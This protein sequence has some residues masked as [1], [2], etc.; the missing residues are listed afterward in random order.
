MSEQELTVSMYREQY[1]DAQQR[2]SQAMIEDDCVFELACVTYGDEF[3]QAGEMVACRP[4]MRILPESGRYQYGILA[5]VAQCNSH[6]LA[7]EE[8]YSSIAYEIPFFEVE[9]ITEETQ[10]PAIHESYYNGLGLDAHVQLAHL[11]TKWT[12]AFAG[13]Y[14]EVP[15][16]VVH[17]PESGLYMSRVEQLEKAYHERSARLGIDRDEVHPPV[18]GVCTKWLAN[19][20]IDP[21]HP[22]FDIQFFL[23]LIER[24]G[25]SG[26]DKVELH[27]AVY[28]PSMGTHIRVAELLGVWGIPPEIVN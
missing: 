6:G 23:G 8:D 20:V 3:I 26:I 15:S 9:A 24:I 2:F 1:L 21:E 28:D 5:C 14:V 11:Y 16:G 27:E 12:A 4:F 18:G 13:T 22:A 17:D 19:L 25:S 7:A 10:W